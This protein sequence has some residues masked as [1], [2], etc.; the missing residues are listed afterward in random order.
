MHDLVVPAAGLDLAGPAHHGRHTPSTFPVG[1]LLPAERCHGRIWP[2]VHVR[3][4]VRGVKDDGVVSN[5][6]LVKQGEEFTDV[7][8]VFDH[9][10]GILVRG[11]VLLFTDRHLLVADMG[12]EVHACAAPPDEPGLACLVLALDEIL[13][14]SH[15]FVIDGFH[16][17]LGQ[18]TC[19]LDLAVGRRLDDT[20]WAIFLAK[21]RI[22]RV[23]LVFGF[24]FCVQ[25]IEIAEKLVETVIGGQHFIAVTEVVLAE[26]AGRI[27]LRLEQAGNRGIL[28]HHSLFGTRQ[29]D[30]GETGTKDALTGNEGGTPCGTGLFTVVVGEG[31]PLLGDTVD[32]G[33]LVAHEAPGVVGDVGL[34]DI[35]SPDHKDVGFVCRSCHSCP[36]EQGTRKQSGRELFVKSHRF[37]STLWLLLSKEVPRGDEICQARDDLCKAFSILN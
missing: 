3:T 5:A 26:L 18:R 37:P 27:A 8:V 28:N 32:V 29:A 17:L 6:Q 30:L 33:G 14:C 9:A 11:R 34:A 20:T 15:G 4:I 31:H 16:A 24:L 35:I 19:V 22:L 25:V 7:H 36:K 12:A 10:A 2:G 13:C 1:V 21:L 23:I